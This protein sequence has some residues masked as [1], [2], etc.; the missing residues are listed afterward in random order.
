M[1]R[2]DDIYVSRIRGQLYTDNT[3]PIKQSKKLKSLESLKKEYGNLLQ[4][5]A[6]DNFIIWKNEDSRS[7]GSLEDTYIGIDDR[8]T[9][10]DHMFHRFGDGKYYTFKPVIQTKY[11]H[12]GDDGYYYMEEWFE[13]DKILQLDDG[14]FLI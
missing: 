1:T 9:V 12:I 10:N 13:Q 6:D 4:M 5:R 7:H 2:E 14:D 3:S 8:L 11:T